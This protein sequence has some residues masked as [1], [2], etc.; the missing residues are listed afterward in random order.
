ME[1]YTRKTYTTMLTC[2]V[3]QIA[4]ISTGHSASFHASF[5]HFCKTMQHV[6]IVHLCV[7]LCFFPT[8]RAHH[9]RHKGIQIEATREQNCIDFLKKKDFCTQNVFSSWKRFKRRNTPRFRT[10]LFGKEAV[11]TFF[12]KCSN[13]GK[14][15][16]LHAN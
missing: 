1:R 2:F 3:T 13:S 6:H 11:K 16:P 9:A 12:Y 15:N 10:L 5:V 7:F 4:T 14:M 8:Q